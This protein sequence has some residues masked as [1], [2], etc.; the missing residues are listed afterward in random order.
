MRFKGNTR[1]QRE[2][3][4]RIWQQWCRQKGPRSAARRFA[5]RLVVDTEARVGPSSHVRDL[6]DD[7]FE[8]AGGNQLNTKQ[9]D[10]A[11]LI[12][13]SVWYFGMSVRNW[14][15]LYGFWYGS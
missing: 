9:R 15:K 12:L 4:E 6:L 8:R 14:A 10:E 13:H 5:E 3:S 2:E 1:Q 11:L 7:A